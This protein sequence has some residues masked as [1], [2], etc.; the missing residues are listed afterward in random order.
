MTREPDAR[1]YF[2]GLYERSDDPWLLR[3]RWYERRK[4]ALTLAMLPDERYARAY[5]PGC[6]NGELSAA[7]ASRCDALLAADLNPDAVE[8]ARRRVAHLGNVQVEQRAIPDEWP[9]GRFDL[10][11][12]SELAYYLDE[13]Q[14]SRLCGRLT[15]SL[16]P[17]GTI[18]AC[19]WRQ[20]IEGWP[21][22]G[23]F[24]H[25]E[26]NATLPFARLSHYLDEDMV[27]DVWSS[28]AD[29]VHRREA[30]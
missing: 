12:V 2:S 23:D 8:L 30:K 5:E 19:H 17:G 16:A 15:E 28:D 1:Q 13:G 10:L 14:L 18:L 11:V 7:L 29:S 6:A 20:P 24:A 3:E 25:V 4:R 22:S 27:L 26:L 21:H 9:D